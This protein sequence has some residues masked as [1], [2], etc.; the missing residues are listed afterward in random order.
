M[1]SNNHAQT[2]NEAVEMGILK[3]LIKLKN[4]QK[5]KKQAINPNTVSMYV[6]VIPTIQTN[7]ELCQQKP[8]KQTTNK[9]KTINLTLKSIYSNRH[10][11]SLTSTHTHISIHR[12]RARERIF[13][14]CVSLW[15]GCPSF[16][17]PQHISVTD[18][19]CCVL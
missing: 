3:K 6:Q 12:E 10:T 15:S 5:A 8:T 17:Y 19:S 13:S 16:L 1:C 9:Q 7:D 2:T 11:V 14:S 4:K 18:I